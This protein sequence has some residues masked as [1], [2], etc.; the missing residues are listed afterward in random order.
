MKSTADFSCCSWYREWHP[1]FFF[2]FSFFWLLIFLG[3]V[4]E[5]DWTELAWAKAE[6]CGIYFK[7][8]KRKARP[9]EAALL[10]CTRGFQLNDSS[11][12]LN[13]IFFFYLSFPFLQ[14]HY[15]WTFLCHPKLTLFFFFPLL[16]DEL[17][18]SSS[19]DHFQT[20]D[21]ERFISCIFFALGVGTMKESF[22]WGMGEANIASATSREKN[23]LP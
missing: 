23:K 12:L 2:F 5:Q 10:F 17:G 14:L 11:T 1:L 22:H 9:C 20:E 4:L 8:R 18:S 6:E 15:A 19:S 13:S 7:L 16:I 3:V 21:L